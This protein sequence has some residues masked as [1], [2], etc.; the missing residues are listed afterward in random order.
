MWE[1]LQLNASIEIKSY[2]VSRSQAYEFNIFLKYVAMVFFKD[3]I[4]S[5]MGD[6]EREAVTQAEGEAGS[7]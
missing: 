7:M 6:T 4:Y 5:F 1:Y 2:Y 3:F